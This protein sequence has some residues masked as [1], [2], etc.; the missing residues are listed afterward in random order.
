MGGFDY[1]YQF[2]V[3][4]DIMPDAIGFGVL[5]VFLVVYLLIL[6]IALAVSVAAYVLQ[7]LGFYTIAE[8]RGIK[9]PWLSWL[10]VGNL[11][12]LGSISDQY[13]YVVK[14]KIRNR[15]KVLLGLSCGLLVFY[16][17]WAVVLIASVAMADMMGSGLVVGLIG[18]LGGLLLVAL[19][20]CLAVFQF[21]CLYDLYRSCMPYNAVVYLVLS[22]LVSWVMPLFVFICR[23]QDVGM[24]PRK[25]PTPP[26][27]YTAP[28][29]P[30][31]PASQEG[32]AQP[33]EFED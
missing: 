33:D 18:I 31:E 7:S 26:P 28:E 11:W 20:I 29:T 2:E 4:T 1:P 22:I 5:G 13:Q 17:V 25:Q 6:L 24:P 10:P 15:R 12:I 14:G 8:R 27:V 23:K 19:A 9:R 30:V 21:I 3:E 16:V 32:F